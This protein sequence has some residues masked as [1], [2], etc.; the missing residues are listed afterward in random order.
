ML[1]GFVVYISFVYNNAYLFWV[2]ITICGWANVQWCEIFVEALIIS[3]FYSY[4]EIYIHKAFVWNIRADISINWMLHVYVSHRRQKVK[5][6]NRKVTNVSDYNRINGNV[7]Y[8][9]GYECMAHSLRQ[10]FHS[11][12]VTQIFNIQHSTFGIELIPTCYQILF[13]KLFIIYIVWRC[14]CCF[15]FYNVVTS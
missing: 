12:I 6:K 10:C 15:F 7:S 9:E 4:K 13:A 8:G 5:A 11:G 14:G 2:L 3:A 1:S